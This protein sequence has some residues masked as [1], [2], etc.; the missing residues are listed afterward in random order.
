MLENV[1]INTHSSIKIVSKDNIVF[2]F[3][4]FKIS[5]E[6]HDANYILITHSHYDHFSPEDILKIK[7]DNTKI[8]VTT[9]LFEQAVDLGFAENDIQF[10]LPNAHY[11]F[12][13]IEFDTIPAY[14]KLKEFHPRKNGWIGYIIKLDD[15]TYYIAGDTD[16]SHEAGLVKCDVALLPIG[17]T[18]TMDAEEAAKLANVIQPKIAVPTHYG[19]IVGSPKDGDI[20]VSL[21]DKDIECVKLIDFK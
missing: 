13:S 6:T 5:E 7:N 8:V 9:D 4:P 2:Y 17:G 1:S 20:F 10:A 19:S 21:L 11:K 18:Y 15:I 16:Y 3:D 14:N 12:D